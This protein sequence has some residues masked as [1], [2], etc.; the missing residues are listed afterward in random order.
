MASFFAVVW[1][2][3][4]YLGPMYRQWAEAHTEKMRNILD[5]TR[6]EHKISVE[7]RI[8]NVKSVAGVVDVTRDLFAVS[9][10]RPKQCF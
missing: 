6:E 7:Y 9:K 5:N 4:N 2:I 10:V 1:A 8:E 3:Y